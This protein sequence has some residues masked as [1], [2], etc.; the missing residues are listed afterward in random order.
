MALLSRLGR[1]G[2]A[3]FTRHAVKSSSG[4]AT[5]LP[6]RCAATCAYSAALP[7]LAEG[8]FVSCKK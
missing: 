7:Q 5:E 8:A 6:W 4:A 2:L 3:A 1:A